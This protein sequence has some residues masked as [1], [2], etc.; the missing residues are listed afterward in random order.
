[1]YDITRVLI[2]N[3]TSSKTFFFFKILFIH[4]RHREKAETWAE[5]EAGSL[6]GA[7][8]GTQS[9]N[10]GDQ[11]LAE[12]RCSTAEPLRRPH[13]LNFFKSTEKYIYYKYLPI[14]IINIIMFTSDYHIHALLS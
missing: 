11:A 8:C 7:G 2:I 6:Q 10:S 9:Q 12:G 3:L 1:M 4:E 14:Y 13:T 5:G